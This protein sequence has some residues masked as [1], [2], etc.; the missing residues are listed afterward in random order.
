[1]SKGADF[2][3]QGR[4]FTAGT[5][6]LD[7]AEFEVRS[8]PRPYK[9]VWTEEPE[10]F[11]GVRSLMGENPANVLFGDEKVFS[12]HAGGKLPDRTLSA[13]ATEEFKT[14]AGV[15]S[16]VDFLMKGGFSKGEKLVVVGG[17]IMEDIG[18][19]SGAV[20]KRGIRWHYFPTTLLSMCDSCIGGKTGINHAGA[21]NQLALFSAPAQVVINP[22]FLKTLDKRD[23][24]S[25]MGEILKLFVTGGPHF[26]ELYKKTVKNG[27]PA[28]FS[29]Y[30]SL[31]LSSLSIKRAVVEYDEFE[32]DHRRSLN[33]GHTIGHVIEALSGYAIPHGQAV[34]IGMIIVNELAVSRGLLARAECDGIKKMAFEILDPESLRVMRSL[35][36]SNI[37]DLLQKDKK[38]VSG[39][40]FLVLIRTAGDTVFVKTNLDAEFKQELDAIVKGEF[41]S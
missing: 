41:Q 35:S 11:A 6:I 20:Y 24:M 36:T 4:K 8:V 17:G 27:L 37:L 18:A 21:K 15:T 7:L 12:L 23:C 3:I 39:S 38:T 16:L 34:S 40:V 30:K 32:L 2:L 14:L 26:V 33:Y 9:V 31:I 10:T 13:K 1:M 19:F 28:E 29:S 22:N 25:G 5:D